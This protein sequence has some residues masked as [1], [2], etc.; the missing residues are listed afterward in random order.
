MLSV[1]NEAAVLVFQLP[2]FQEA[3]GLTN[4][5]H[6]HDFFVDIFML[7]D[8]SPSHIEIMYHTLDDYPRV[9]CRPWVQ[10]KHMEYCVC[11]VFLKILV[12]D[13]LMH[14]DK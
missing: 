10:N 7:T 8:P 12:W 2:K 13:T 4:E 1:S 3:K 6:I 14:G 11:I 5:S 9:P